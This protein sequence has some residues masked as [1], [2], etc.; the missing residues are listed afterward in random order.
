MTVEEKNFPDGAITCSEAK[1]RERDEV[2]EFLK[3]SVIMQW[4]PTWILEE[5][6]GQQW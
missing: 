2:L 5:A 4:P 6:T 3:V 1:V